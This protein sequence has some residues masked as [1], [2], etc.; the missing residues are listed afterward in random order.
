MDGIDWLPSVLYRSGQ[1]IDMKRLSPEAHKKDI[2]I[3]IDLAHSIGALP[4]SLHDW[5]VDFAVWCNCKYRNSR[6]GGGGGMFVHELH[7]GTAP[8]LAGWFRDPGAKM[9]CGS[10][11]TTRNSPHLGEDKKTMNWCLSQ[12][13]DNTFINWDFGPSQ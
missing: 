7:L 10:D 4:H 11:S 8:G 2:L 12:N 13:S 6:P 1:L 5:G 9:N 3:G